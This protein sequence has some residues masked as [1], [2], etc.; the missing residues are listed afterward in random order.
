[1]CTHFDNN[2]IHYRRVAPTTRSTA[3]LSPCRISRGPSNVDVPNFRQL[4]DQSPISLALQFIEEPYRLRLQARFGWICVGNDGFD[5]H[6]YYARRS[7]NP[8]FDL[9][10]SA[11]KCHYS[12]VEEMHRH[13]FSRAL[14]DIH[15]QTVS[16]EV[17]SASICS[18]SATGF[19]NALGRSFNSFARVVPSTICQP[20]I[21]RSRSR[22]SACTP[23]T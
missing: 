7:M 9:R 16:I 10:A 11:L 21:R 13:K 23:N 22:S 6:S 1:M 18:N 8:S 12:P 15:A 14:F 20:I 4:R 2:R 5:L 17:P 3:E 19:G